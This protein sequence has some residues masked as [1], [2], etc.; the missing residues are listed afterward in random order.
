MT[1]RQFYLR[2]KHINTN[3]GLLENSFNFCFQPSVCFLHRAGVRQSVRSSLTF[4]I[5]TAALPMKTAVIKKKGGRWVGVNGSSNREKRERERKRRK[6]LRGKLLK[7]VQA[8][9][10]GSSSKG[11]GPLPSPAPKWR[12]LAPPLNTQCLVAKLCLSLT[13]EWGEERKTGGGNTK[14]C[15]SLSF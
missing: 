7:K 9:W 3:S 8:G 5:S 14:C 2:T 6:C 13:D 12:L 11:V 1:K 4:L 10:L 15:Y